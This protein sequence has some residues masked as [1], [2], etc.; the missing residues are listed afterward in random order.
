MGYS[1]TEGI[2]S[3]L[4][5]ICCIWVSFFWMRAIFS[6]MRETYFW[7]RV[8]FIWMRVIFFWMRVIFFWMWEGDRNP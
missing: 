5:K 8:S 6:W 7:M 4:T 3:N 1:V 2:E